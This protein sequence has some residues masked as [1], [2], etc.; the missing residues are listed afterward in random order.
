MYEQVK[1]KKDRYF[2]RLVS[3]EEAERRL[4]EGKAR[5]GGR[6]AY[7]EEESESEGEKEGTDTQDNTQPLKLAQDG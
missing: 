6:H 5:L 4:S 2:P 1:R 7:G 3:E